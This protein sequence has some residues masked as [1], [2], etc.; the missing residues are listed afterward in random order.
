MSKV[1]QV[2][3]RRIRSLQTNARD[4]RHQTARL[5]EEGQIEPVR[6]VIK[7]DGTYTHLELDRN[8]PDFWHYSDALVGAALALNWPT[9]LVSIRE[10]K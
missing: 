4:I 3:P 9:I 2:D 6:V 7:S 10:E 8:H 5:E 1:K